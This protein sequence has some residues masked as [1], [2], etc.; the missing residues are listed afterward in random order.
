[1]NITL[2]K[3]LYRMSVLIFAKFI[4]LQ[5][6]ILVRKM[7]K[8]FKKVVCVVVALVKRLSELLKH[9][10]LCYCCSNF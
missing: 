10:V 6:S 5:F 4:E 2:S 1:M 8:L 3:Y 7:S 9:I